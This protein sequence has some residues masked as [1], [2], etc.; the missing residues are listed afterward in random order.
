MSLNCKFE[1]VILKNPKYNF[2]SLSKDQIQRKDIDN[3]LLMMVEL[4]VLNLMLKD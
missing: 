3:G 4:N 2:E 1:K